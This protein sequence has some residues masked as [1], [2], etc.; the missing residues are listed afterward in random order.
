MN[1]EARQACVDAIR[2]V[3]SL[4]YD[5]AAIDQCLNALRGRL[6][7]VAAAD[8]VCTEVEALLRAG[9][10]PRAARLV[11]ELP[12]RGSSRWGLWLGLALVATALLV[13]GLFALIH[14]QV[15]KAKALGSA[16]LLPPSGAS[17][18]AEAEVTALSAAF[19][20]DLAAGRGDTAYA[21]MS[22][23]YRAVV[24][25]ARF[26]AAIA[27]NLTLRGLSRP[28]LYNLRF[29]SGTASVKGTLLDADGNRV[30]FT[31][32]FARDPQGWGVTA[33]AVR[34]VAV[35]PQGPP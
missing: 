18:R 6:A 21:R 30:S 31:A 33:F 20:G 22:A 25:P 27:A 5:P 10:A 23:P 2:Q 16:D 15:E 28:T 9:N 4:R 11:E 14:S 26:S 8:A 24:T 35:L 19:V 12:L 29:E 3:E 17:D 34:N 32:S 13:F 7:H 1:L